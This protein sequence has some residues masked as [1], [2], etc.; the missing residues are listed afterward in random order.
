VGEVASQPEGVTGNGCGA[1]GSVLDPPDFRFKSVC[2]D[3]D[4]KYAKGGTREQRKE[5]DRDMRQGMLLKA[6]FA[7]WY[8]RAYLVPAAWTYWAAVRVGGWR[9]WGKATP[10]P[11]R[12]K[13]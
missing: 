12:R 8:K 9:H 3:H 2:D 7:P 13:S 1:E 11:P 6:S 5:A 10:P 4:L